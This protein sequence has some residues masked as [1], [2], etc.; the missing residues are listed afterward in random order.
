[1]SRFGLGWAGAYL[2]SGAVCTLAALLISRM[3]VKDAPPPKA[4]EV[5]PAR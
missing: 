5:S 2:M 1:M 4:V 3:E